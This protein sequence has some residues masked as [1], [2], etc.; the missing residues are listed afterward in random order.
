MEVYKALGCSPTVARVCLTGFDHAQTSRGAGG[1]AVRLTTRI[2]ADAHLTTGCHFARFVISS[3]ISYVATYCLPVPAPR[4]LH[5]V[6]RGRVLTVLLASL[7]RGQDG[8]R[9]GRSV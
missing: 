1:T 3:C 5:R 4:I 2:P 6:P 7:R 9:I 8:G